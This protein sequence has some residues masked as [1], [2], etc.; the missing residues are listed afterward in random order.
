MSTQNWPQDPTPRHATTDSGASAA[1]GSDS[2]S[3]TSDAAKGEAREVGKQGAEAGQHVA[4]VAKGETKEV[5]HE[6]KGQAKNLAHELGDDLKSQA[7]SQQ[8]KVAEGLRSISDELNSM[9]QNSDESGT[10]TQWV[11]Q[12]GQRTGD[13]AGWL[14]QRDPAGLLDETRR[15]ARNRPGAFL[16]IAAGAG[17]LAG[18][19]ARGL[20]GGNDDG[21]TAGGEN[22]RRSAGSPQTYGSTHATEYPAV[23]ET[24]PTTGVPTSGAATVGGGAPVGTGPGT[25]TGG[26]GPTGAMGAGTDSVT[27]R[28]DPAMPDLASSQAPGYRPG[29][30]DAE[31]GPVN[32]AYPDDDARGLNEGGDK[33]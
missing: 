21:G 30:P 32:P 26:R 28:E 18:R 20:Q 24:A 25:G 5:A 10:A 19:L 12:A 17:L 14:D 1:T 16:A 6:A 23:P 33:R 7:E 8:K 3:S 9:A 2:G 4:D 15:F 27:A 22:G 13:I 29:F 31:P 11:Q